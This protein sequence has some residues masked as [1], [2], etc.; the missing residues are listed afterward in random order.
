MT[1]ETWP[2][3]VGARLY[4]TREDERRSKN[5]AFANP[6]LSWAVY[7]SPETLEIAKMG[8]DGGTDAAEAAVRA[9]GLW[10][11]PP[12]LDALA[13]RVR[14]SPRFWREFERPAA[15]APVTPRRC[16]RGVLW[17]YYADGD[18]WLPDLTDAATRGCLCDLAGR[19]TDDVEALVAAL[20]VAP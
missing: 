16:S 6:P 1:G 12:D 18:G 11:E 14:A 15:S 8:W 2:R 19:W 10:P 5:I 3:W 13:R 20:E 17:R 9:L 4:L 7:R